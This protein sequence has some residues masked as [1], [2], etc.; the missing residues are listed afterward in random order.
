MHIIIGYAVI[1]VFHNFKSNV[2]GGDKT[3]FFFKSKFSFVYLSDIITSRSLSFIDHTSPQVF[4][5]A[6]S[7][8]NNMHVSSLNIFHSL[9][10]YH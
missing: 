1:L 6:L 9:I 7:H 8:K 10:F 3:L 4:F 2:S 5:H